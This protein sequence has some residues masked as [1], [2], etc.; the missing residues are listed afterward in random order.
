MN[1]VLI[2]LL[3]KKEKK[4]KADK[5]VNELCGKSMCNHMRL[6]GLVAVC[7]VSVLQGK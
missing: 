1:N 3:E 4:V 2:K 7:S 5:I 6:Y